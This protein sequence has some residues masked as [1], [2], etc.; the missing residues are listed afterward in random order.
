MTDEELARTAVSV[1]SHYL[2]R[3]S[4]KGP[5]AYDG[6]LEDLL[7][8]V[9]ARFADQFLG[10]V[11]ARFAERP[12]ELVEAETMR[13]HLGKEAARDTVFSRELTSALAGRKVKKVRNPGRWARAAVL[14]L[15]VLVLLVSSFVV[16]RLTAP[17]PTVPVATSATTVTL[18][19][20]TTSASASDVIG[21]PMPTTTESAT[22]SVGPA[23]A[24]DGGSVPKDSPVLMVDLPRPNDAWRVAHGDHDVQLTQYQ[25]SMWTMLATCNTTAYRGEQQFRRRTSLAWKRRR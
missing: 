8:R 2:Q 11:F 24:G 15:V 1:L 20:P 6:P 19:P 3:R 22:G 7:N 21:T 16:G 23:V 5:A 12:A 14:V 10:E 18:S 25:D 4:A 9:Q 17:G 13:L